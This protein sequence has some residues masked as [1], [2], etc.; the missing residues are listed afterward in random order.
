[1]Y[2]DSKLLW[3]LT[4]SKSSKSHTDIYHNQL[5]NIWEKLKSMNLPFIIDNNIINNLI[6]IVNIQFIFS[7]IFLSSSP[8]LFLLLVSIY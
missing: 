3:G 4:N 7:F 5:K 2:H 8:S 6:H 1:M